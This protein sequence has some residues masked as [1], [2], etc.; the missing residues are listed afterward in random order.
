MK[1][2]IKMGRKELDWEGTDSIDL[3]QDMDK[4]WAGVNAVMNLQFA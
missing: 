2:N 4:R 1:N 3:A